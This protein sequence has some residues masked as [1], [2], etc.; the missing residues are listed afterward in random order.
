MMATL[1]EVG[2]ALHEFAGVRDPAVV[3]HQ[4]GHGGRMQAG[5][6]GGKDS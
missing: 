5:D 4:T 1:V 3:I 6:Q 2:T